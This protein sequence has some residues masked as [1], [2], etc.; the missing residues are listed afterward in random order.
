[1]EILAEQKVYIVK[2]KLGET[3]GIVG[4]FDNQ[5]AAEKCAEEK[6]RV[7]TGNTKFNWGENKTAQSVNI[8][9]ENE[10]AELKGSLIIFQQSVRS[11]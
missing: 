4:V 8:N 7:W 3:N 10:N 1:M 9:S 5:L 11:K 6:Y 2:A